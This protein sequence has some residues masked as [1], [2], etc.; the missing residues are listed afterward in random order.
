MMWEYTMQ[1]LNP[2]CPVDTLNA[3][4]AEEWEL[5]QIQN[6]LGTFKRRFYPQSPLVPYEIKLER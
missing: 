4:G 3:F 5:V 1:F 2:S 6:G